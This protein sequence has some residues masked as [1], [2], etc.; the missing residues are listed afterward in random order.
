MN[1]KEIRE[2]HEIVEKTPYSLFVTLVTTG[3]RMYRHSVNTL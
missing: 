3:F 1:L 2:R